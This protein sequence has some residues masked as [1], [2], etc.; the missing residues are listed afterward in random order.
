MIGTLAA[1][2]GRF[3]LLLL[4]QVLVLD[5][6]DVANGWMVPYLYVLFLLMLPFE[7]PAWGV[8]L[9]GATIGMAMDLFSSTP[10][11]HMSACVAMAFAR[12]HLLRLMAPRE[13]YEFGMR[14]TVPRMGLPWF[15]TYAGVLIVLH[16]LW[17]FIVEIHR[18]DALGATLLRALMS[19]AFTLALCLLAQFLTSAAQE[20]SRA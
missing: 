3:I 8:L 10:G 12:K 5:H 15:A 16:H 11:M 4:L 1:N 6:L 14:P 19:A 17:L 7:V 13:G 9:L 20:R 18:F 2:I